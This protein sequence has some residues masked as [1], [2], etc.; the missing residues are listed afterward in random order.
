MIVLFR[1]SVDFSSGIIIY[2]WCYFFRV[3]GILTE[4]NCVCQ[5]NSLTMWKV[6]Q[7][8][9]RFVT[10]VYFF[11]V[12]EGGIY[13]YSISTSSDMRPRLKFKTTFVRNNLRL[14]EILDVKFL[15]PYSGPEFRDLCD[16]TSYIYGL[17]LHDYK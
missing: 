17:N 6:I 3:I 4:G 12:L 16:T 11:T 10:H 9:D 2:F 5:R 8:I 1:K 14:R 7:L 13:F 15:S